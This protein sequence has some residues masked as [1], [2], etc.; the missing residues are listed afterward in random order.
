MTDD[1]TPPPSRTSAAARRRERRAR[2]SAERRGERGAADAVGSIK[3]AGFAA[4]LLVFVAVAAGF[5]ESEA[6]QRLA[7]AF[8]V[9]GPLAE[10]GF[11]GV[12]PLE[13]IGLVIVFAIIARLAIKATR[14]R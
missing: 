2:L 9:L 11:L 1:E 5:R 8:A 13:W 14:R 6:A 12:S 3:F 10:P 7:G 4:A